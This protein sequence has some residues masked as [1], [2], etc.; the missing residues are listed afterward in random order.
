MKIERAAPPIVRTQHLTGRRVQ[1]VDFQYVRE[2]DSD[3]RI[4]RWLFGKVQ[5]EGESSFAG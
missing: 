4:Q 5:T 2:S 1:E 3:L